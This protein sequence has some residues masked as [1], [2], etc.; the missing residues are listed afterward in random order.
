MCYIY[1]L[2]LVLWRKEMATVNQ[3]KCACPKC[4]C[5]VSTDTSIVKDGKYYCSQGCAE[6][7]QTIQGCGHKGCDC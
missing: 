2:H 4:L 5:I 3:L 1:S 6:G 7:H